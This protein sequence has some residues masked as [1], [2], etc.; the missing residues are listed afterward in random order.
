MT[1]EEIAAMDKLHAITPEEWAV[2]MKKA[3][4]D[5]GEEHL[6]DMT[7]TG[8]CE[9][10][11]VLTDEQGQVT[12]I[13]SCLVGHVAY[14][15]DPGLLDVLHGF[16]GLSVGA[17]FREASNVS[18]AL[19]AAQTAQDTGDTWGEALRKFQ[20]IMGVDDD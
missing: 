7:A 18:I 5:K 3:V 19:D 9:Y 2:A 12:L 15:I 17:L 4:A 8:S 6:Y 11:E 1:P 16:E 14:M 13:P 10:A 20:E